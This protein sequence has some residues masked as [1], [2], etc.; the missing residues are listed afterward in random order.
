M[1]TAAKKKAPLS[2]RRRKLYGKIEIA[3]KELA[4]SVAKGVAFVANAEKAAS[5]AERGARDAG[6]R[7]ARAAAGTFHAAGPA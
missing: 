6:R 3:K 7:D 2:L 1:G 5:S 4:A